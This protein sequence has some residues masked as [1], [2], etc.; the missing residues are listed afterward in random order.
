MS[1]IK[2]LLVAL[3]IAFGGL[4]LTASAAP[5]EA[6]VIEAVVFS[7]ERVQ[8]DQDGNNTIDD[9]GI[10]EQYGPITGLVGGV[11]IG[12]ERIIAAFRKFKETTIDNA[13]AER[14]TA[15]KVLEEERALNREYTSQL[16][17][18]RE[19]SRKEAEEIKARLH[20]ETISRERKHRK[21]IEE[22][23]KDHNAVTE[24][25]HDTLTLEVHTRRK[26]ENL[27]AANGIEFEDEPPPYTKEMKRE[28]TAQDEQ[29]AEKAINTGNI[30]V[31]DQ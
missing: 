23:Y 10:V 26:R 16:A 24:N 8:Q 18:E 20:N 29:E 12:I 3:A 4:F 2:R 31:V 1:F 7:A 25:L 21:E 27:L 22:L 9:P 17:A 14:D 6:A 28:V 30:P 13:I 15:K 5:T 11:L 19:S